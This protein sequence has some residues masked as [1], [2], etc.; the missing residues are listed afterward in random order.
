[1][2]MWRSTVLDR[3]ERPTDFEIWQDLS[4]LERFTRR[5][6]MNTQGNGHPRLET[7]AVD[8]SK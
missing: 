2:S 7:T 6:W 1:M 3:G 5:S 8:L 4:K